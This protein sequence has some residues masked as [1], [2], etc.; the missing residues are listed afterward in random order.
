M[1]P[2]RVGDLFFGFLRIALSGFGGVLPWA[3]RMMVEEKRWMTDAEFVDI[4]AM[5]QLLPGPN[6]VNVAIGTGARFH[7]A[8]GALAAF[9]GL[10][11]APVAIVIVLGLLY[12]RYGELAPLRSAFSGIAAV[13][14]G[15]VLTT[16]FRISSLVR[17]RPAALVIAVLAFVGAGILRW[18]LGWI[19]LGLAPISLA[20]A[21]WERR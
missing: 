2:P 16:A 20:V 21:M 9:A 13:A 4:L 1:T 8:L 10:M 14:A 19:V 6:I 7:G 12:L 5:A 3:R 17:G 18:P 15:M 11:V